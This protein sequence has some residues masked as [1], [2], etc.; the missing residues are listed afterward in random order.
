MI[1]STRFVILGGGNG[2]QSLAADLSEQGFHVAALYDRFPEMIQPVKER[3]GVEMIGPVRSGFGKVDLVTSNIEEAISAGDVLFVVVP[4]FA[5]E[6]IA[7]QAAPHLRDGQMIVLTPGY[8]GGTVLFRKIFREKSVNTKVTLAETQGLPYS[9]RIVGPAQVGIQ[10]VKKRLLIATLPAPETERVLDV[11]KPALP[12]LEPTDSILVTG[13]NNPNPISH[14]PGYLMNQGR[15]AS[16]IPAGQFDWHEWITPEI[17]RVE[18]ALDNERKLVTEGLGVRFFSIEEIIEMYYV[19]ESWEIIQPTGE[20]P[21]SAQTIPP[22][23]I[24]EDVPMGLV[25]IA[26]LAKMLG[27]E[28]PIINS[29]ITLASTFK[30]VDYWEEGR[31]LEKLGLTGMSPQQIRA[32][33]EQGAG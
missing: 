9:T 30:G 1:N 19:G 29:L 8:I 20:I 25:P 14:V 31:T 16:D 2:G 26:S 17:E 23:F 28:T 12:M 32:L 10:G 7:E 15:I 27:L 18:A 3:G 22:R 11:L 13:L 33:V 24:T 6:W 4:A 21:Q 5:H